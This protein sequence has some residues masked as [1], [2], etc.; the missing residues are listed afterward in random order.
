M[1]H[2]HAGQSGI[3]PVALA[4]RYAAPIFLVVLVALF[5]LLSFQVQTVRSEVRLAERDIISLE[6]EVQDILAR[7]N[8]EATTLLDEAGYELTGRSV[9][10]QS[11]S[12]KWG[13]D[14]KRE[15][16]Q[17]ANARIAAQVAHAKAELERQ[18]TENLQTLILDSLETDAALVFMNSI[19]TVAALVPASR[20]K[21]LES[22][23]DEIESE[24]K[25]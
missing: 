9:F 25:P 12:I 13:D 10:G 1:S 18:E 19:P 16:R 22:M 14:G 15:M 4:A 2:S 24:G 7:A 23:L 20:M 21:E 6:R 11:Y 17:A 8:R 5:A 3:D